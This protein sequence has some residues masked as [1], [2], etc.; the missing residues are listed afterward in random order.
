WWDSEQPIK[1]WW[2]GEVQRQQKFR[3]SEKDE[4]YYLWLHDH[5]STS[6]WR[7]YNEAAKPPKFGDNPG[8]ETAPPLTLGQGMHFWL[9]Q[10]PETI[11][12]TLASDLGMDLPQVSWNFGELRAPEMQENMHEYDYHHQL[13]LYRRG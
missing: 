13:G 9:D 1:P 7:W 11:Y 12:Q 3:L 6:Y 10:S 5:H 4:A 2:C 8:I